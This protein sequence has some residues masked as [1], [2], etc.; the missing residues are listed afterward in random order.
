MSGAEAKS[1]AQK[2]LKASED[3]IGQVGIEVKDLAAELV[4]V[5]PPPGQ[6][7][8]TAP[9]AAASASESERA[10]GPSEGVTSSGGSTQVDKDASQESNV[11]PAS[12]EPFSWE[13]GDDASEAKSGAK[14]DGDNNKS[15]KSQDPAKSRPSEET[16][17][18]E[19]STRPPT[20]DFD[21]DASGSYDHSSKVVDD[22][23]EGQTPAGQDKDDGSDS[24]SDWE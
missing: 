3:L 6:D 19:A 12:E 8:A 5:V 17:R 22:S 15:A 9:Q 21:G 1:Y 10:G 4:R 11:A 14:E 16:Q 7:E 2:Y 13:E 24:D 18:L 20:G 23:N